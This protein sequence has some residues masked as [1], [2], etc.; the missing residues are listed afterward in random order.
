VAGDGWAGDNSRHAI[1]CVMG[2]LDVGFRFW[3]T[4]RT[5]VM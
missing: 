5:W 3:L 1:H 2:A 4:W